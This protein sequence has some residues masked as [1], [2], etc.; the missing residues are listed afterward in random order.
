MVEHLPLLPVP[1]YPVP[2][3]GSLRLLLCVHKLNGTDEIP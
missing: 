2:Y 1:L 3:V